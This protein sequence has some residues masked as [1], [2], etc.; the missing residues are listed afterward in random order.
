MSCFT[1]CLTSCSLVHIWLTLWCTFN[2]GCGCQLKAVYTSNK[3]GGVPVSCQNEIYDPEWKVL[4]L[5]TLWKLRSAFGLS[6]VEDH[7]ANTC[8]SGIW[9]RRYGVSMTVDTDS[10]LIPKLSVKGVETKICAKWTIL[11]SVLQQNGFGTFRYRRQMGASWKWRRK[12]HVFL[13]MLVL[14][15]FASNIILL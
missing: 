4:L 8:W 1:T 6:A 10:L 15:A 9:I 5:D 13:Y 11:C 12:Q 3:G 7:G 2:A 14:L